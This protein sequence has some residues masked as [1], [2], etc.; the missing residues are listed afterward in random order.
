[1]FADSLGHC[2]YLFERDCSVQRRHQKV[3]EEAPAPGMTAERRAAMGQAAVEAAR[4]V[5]YV[6]AGT[7]EFIVH[8]D[9]RFYF[10]EMNTR[11]QVEHPVT[12]MITGLDLVEWQLRVAF[13][14]P[15]PRTQGELAISG[16]AIEARIYAEDPDKGFL[17]STGRLLHLA[18][19]AQGDSVRV[20]TGVEQGDA[21]TPFYDPMIA[22]LIVHAPDRAGAIAKMKA[23]LAQ[24]RIVGVANNVEFLGR[25]VGSDSFVRADLDTALIER[26][27]AALFPAAAQPPEDAW[28]LAALAEVERDAAAARQAAERAVDAGSPWRALDGWRLNGSAVRRLGFRDA[29]SMREVDVGALPG[30]A[31]QLT[32]D[33]VTI[34]ATAALA[35]DGTLTAALGPRRLSAT[36]VASGD[37]RHVFVAGRGHVLSHV[38]LLGIAGAEH[39]EEGAGLLAPMPGKVIALL[40]K[41]GATVDKGAP[42]L[43]LEAMKMEHTISAPRAGTVKGFRYAAGDQVAEGAEL[44]EFE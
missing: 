34:A 7:V 11:L 41:P 18:P 10:M 38:D 14:E 15:L 31:W 32:L 21:I 1:V 23:A 25:L 6:G 33:G 44:V 40:A 28:L 36:V 3:L 2:V 30:G 19:P 4:A 17:P 39:D 22:K 12:E 5:G 8:P 9:G 27:H 29:E 37:Q 43:V 13:G 26:E 35:A 20:D 24:Y 42:L 16:H